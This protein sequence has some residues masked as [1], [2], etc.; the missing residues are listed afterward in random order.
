MVTRTGRHWQLL[1]G[2]ALFLLPFL[3]LP[4]VLAGRTRG[5]P[6]AWQRLGLSAGAVDDIAMAAATDGATYIYAAVRGQGVFRRVGDGRW[7]AMNTGLPQGALGRVSPHRL[8]VDPRDGLRAWVAV[9]NEAGGALYATTDG[10]AHWHPA[11]E[12]LPGHGRALVWAPPLR[13]GGGGRLFLALTD[14]LWRSDDGG[15]TWEQLAAWPGA[16]EVASLAVAAGEPET[17]YLGA[18]GGLFRSSDG[19]QSWQRA[20]AGLGNLTART[21]ALDP[22]HPERLFVGTTL[23]VYVTTNSGLTWEPLG[24]RLGTAA[25][26]RLLFVPPQTAGSPATLVAGLEGGGVWQ[27]E[28]PSGLK[29]APTASSG[30]AGWRPR[31]A[32]MGAARVNALL[33]VPDGGALLA[34][35][36]TTLLRYPLR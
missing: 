4:T 36:E 7:A 1:L 31:H 15:T 12:G 23:G 30:E 18:V 28:L 26:R 25:V 2:L 19:G 3:A 22:T 17:I 10:G 21:I 33:L 6:A 27:F 9:V 29:I 24:F 20:N 11:L 32:G 5:D 16:A 8:L 34:G 14:A 35:T 13:E